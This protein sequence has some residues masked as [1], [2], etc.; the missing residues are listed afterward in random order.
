M[1]KDEREKQVR[2]ARA[3]AAKSAAALEAP[4]ESE[5][6]SDPNTYL[7]PGHVLGKRDEDDNDSD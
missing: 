7:G 5:E 4:P 2:E 3:A 1:E 6:L